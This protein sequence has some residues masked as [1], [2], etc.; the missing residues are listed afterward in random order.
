MVGFQRH[1]ILEKIWLLDF[2]MKRSRNF[3]EPSILAH[4]RMVAFF[5]SF[6]ALATFNFKCV[7]LAGK[8]MIKCATFI[9]IKDV[10]QCSP[11]QQMQKELFRQAAPSTFMLLDDNGALF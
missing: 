6:H 2:A 5:I 10:F 8:H 3:K 7:G 4:T 11:G 1:D 9:G